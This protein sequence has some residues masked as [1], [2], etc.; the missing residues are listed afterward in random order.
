MFFIN[1]NDIRGYIDSMTAPIIELGSY[2]AGHE[3]SFA[4]A[5]IGDK[6]Y[7]MKVLDSGHSN[8]AGIVLYARTSDIQNKPIDFII[9]SKDECYN[10][11]ISII[12]RQE[13]GY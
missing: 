8:V 4:Y 11:T 9:V 12:P 2:V 1:E 3:I 13:M 7:D 5:K 10:Q 6:Y